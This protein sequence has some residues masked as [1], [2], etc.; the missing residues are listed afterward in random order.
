M[1][2]EIELVLPVYPHVTHH[3][4]KESQ[5]RMV[6]PKRLGTKTIKRELLSSCATENI[7]KNVLFFLSHGG[8]MQ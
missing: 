7:V 1:L 5:V 4:F 2:T 6:S 3:Q 8:A